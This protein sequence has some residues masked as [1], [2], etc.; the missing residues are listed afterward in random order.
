MTIP[1]ELMKQNQQKGSEQQAKPM[2]GVSVKVDQGGRTRQTARQTDRQF[3]RETDREESHIDRLV[4]TDKDRQTQ[5]SD[6]RTTTDRWT[7]KQTKKMT[8]R[9]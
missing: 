5:N 1:T 2:E 7:C 6:K 8:D 3:I 4:E 9:S